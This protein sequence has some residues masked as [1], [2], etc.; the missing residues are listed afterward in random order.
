MD[1]IVTRRPCVDF[2]EVY[3]QSVK[4]FLREQV[5]AGW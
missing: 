3:V 5:G 2:A 1:V 4:Q